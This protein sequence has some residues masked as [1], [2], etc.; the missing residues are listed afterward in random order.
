M[1]MD[2]FKASNAALFSAWEQKQLEALNDNPKLAAVVNLV[3]KIGLT[4]WYFM[5]KQDATAQFHHFYAN[6]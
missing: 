5:K 6:N 3:E 1:F 4:S 2:I